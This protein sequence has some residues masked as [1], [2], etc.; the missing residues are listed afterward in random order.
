MENYEVLEKIGGGSF[1]SV[2]KIKRRRDGKVLVWKELNYGRMSDKEKQL[3]VSE[4][5]ILR[6]LKSPHIVRYYDR[7]I[8]REN[9]KI[10]IVTEYCE[11]GD[12]ASLISK[13]KR[14]RI[15]IDEDTVWRV[16]MQLALALGDCHGRKEG[17]VLH[18]DLKPANVFL[19]GQQ[20][21]K[22]GDFGLARIMGSS[23]ALADT[24][25][26]TPFYMSPEQINEC[27][28]NAMS[29]V[30]SLG[31]LVYEMC[32]LNHPFEATNQIALAAKIK[33]GKFARLPP[34]YSS[35]VFRVIQMMLQV[36]HKRRPTIDQLL[37]LPP[38]QARLRERNLA[39]QITTVKQREDAV[40]MQEEAIVKREEQI[41]AREEQ[42]RVRE[43]Q[44]RSKEE[45][46]GCA[47]AV[48]GA[49]PQSR[50]NRGGEAKAPGAYNGCPTGHSAAPT[51]IPTPAA[52]PASGGGLLG[53]EAFAA[54]PLA[55]GA[56]EPHL[57][58]VGGAGLRGGGLGVVG[59]AVPKLLAR[60]QSLPTLLMRDACMPPPVKADLTLPSLAP[61]VV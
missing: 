54:R 20:N 6:E 23:S 34:K 25:V 12:L 11:G 37:A 5:N 2:F 18:R 55:R 38:F 30:W 16:L 4:V 35:E 33:L 42:L 45:K 31:C 26:G 44:V 19:D 48:P 1:G 29:D 50:S 57:L 13:C 17:P 21:V 58:G 3:L 24:H 51:P 61:A 47:P 15:Q 60:E 46:L 40:R 43:E 14:E 56:S 32:T 39:K 22:L 7:I 10:Y 59:A 41:R 27:G 9:T 8:D 36:D 53:K 49:A 28:Y 52:A